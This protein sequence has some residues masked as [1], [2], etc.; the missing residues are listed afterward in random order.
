MMEIVHDL[1]A[2]L[3]SWHRSITDPIRLFE[4]AT[5]FTAALAVAAVGVVAQ[6]QCLRE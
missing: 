1:A 3:L 6:S 5:A 4:D 2:T